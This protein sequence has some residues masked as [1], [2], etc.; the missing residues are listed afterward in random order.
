LKKP[1]GIKNHSMAKIIFTSRYIRNASRAG[2]LVKYMGTREGVEKLPY[3][4]DHSPA[5]KKQDDLIAS[6][7]KK[8]PVSSKY[9]EYFEYQQK[10]EKASATEFIDAFVERNS[11]RIGNFKKLVSYIAERPSVEKLGRHGL[12]SQTDDKI[13]IDTVAEEVASHQGILW[14]HIISLRREDAERLGYNNAEAWKKAFRRNII[15]IAEA[16]KIKVSDLKWYAAFHN[17]T[18]HPH[19]HLLVFSRD[20]RTGYLTNKGIESMRSAFARDLFR[21]EQ[22]KLFQMET[23]QRDLLKQT[24][25]K[26][27]ENMDISRE[28]PPELVALFQTLVTQLDGYRGKRVYGYLPKPMKETVNKIVD[29]LAKEPTVSQTYDAWCEINRAKLSVYSEQEKPFVPLS[30]NDVFRSIKNTIL[31][32]SVYL[33]QLS[34]I[35]GLTKET[36][37]HSCGSFYKGLSTILAKLIGSDCHKKLNNL[38]GQVDSKL[39]QQINEKKVAQGL[40]ISYTPVEDDEDEDENEDF[41]LIL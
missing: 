40:K 8:Y 36:F 18:H 16:H 6:I 1:T 4:V 22:Y 9:P 13:D 7:V 5:T 11:D 34:H 21:N 10:K 19:V 28:A 26:L 27:L 41:G 25:N 15:S 30:E 38:E 12:F 37:Q 2:N 32:K 20:P 24:V 29:E 14:T 31:Q 39:R 33:L 17:T 35:E 3:G 23:Q